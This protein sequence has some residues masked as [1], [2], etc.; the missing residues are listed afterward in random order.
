VPHY[1]LLVGGGT[2]EGRARFGRPVVQLPAR[3]VPDAIGALLDTFRREG[4]PDEGFSA[5][6]ERVGVARLKSLLEPYR[7]VPDY[8]EAP[9][10]YRDLGAG[11]QA[12]Q[13]RLG[14]GEC[15][16]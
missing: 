2:E 11:G 4:R 5:Y 8:G 13:V 12:F 14:R 9:E 6:V 15:A 7:A 10:W 3:R 16:G 1:L